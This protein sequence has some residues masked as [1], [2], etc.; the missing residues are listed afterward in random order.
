M[1]S[2]IA[3]VLISVIATSL[4]W[5]QQTPSAPPSATPSAL[6]SATPSP[7]PPTDESVHRLLDVM[8]AKKLVEGIPQQMDAYLTTML[9]KMLEGK[10]ISEKRQQSIDKLRQ[11]VSDLMRENFNWASMEPMY[12]EVY[13]KTFSQAEVNS[14]IT[15]YSSP[16]GSAVVQ[17]LPLVM[18]NTLSIMQQHMQQLL[19]K[20][21]K[22]AKD[23]AVDGDPA[24]PAAKDKSG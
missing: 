16:E 7:P 14:M 18:Q 1:K 8:Q 5:A 23:A 20:I 4:T 6:P 11:S 13:E 15:F 9:N 24:Q 22:M 10:T 21:Q 2:F 19:P 12:L 17:K 3:A